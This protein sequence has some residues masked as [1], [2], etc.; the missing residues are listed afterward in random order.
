MKSFP[1]IASSGDIVWRNTKGNRH[2]GDG[3]PAVIRPSGSLGYY[4]DGKPFGY[5]NP[6]GE[7]FITDYF[8]RVEHPR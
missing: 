1:T 5:R 6:G 2:R 3:K 7:Y 4:A 8:A